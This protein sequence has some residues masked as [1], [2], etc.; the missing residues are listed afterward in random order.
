MRV[1]LICAV[2]VLAAAGCDRHNDPEAIPDNTPAPT[3]RTATT[4]EAAG[5]PYPASASPSMPPADGTGPAGTRPLDGD[6]AMPATP[7]AEND[8]DCV[9]PVPDPA[10]EPTTTPPAVPPS[11]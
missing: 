8:P 5:D 1:P 11:Q 10:R 2:L 9:D 6:P 7:C 4:P 3:D